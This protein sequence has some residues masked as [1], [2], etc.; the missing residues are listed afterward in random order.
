M[1]YL[2]QTNLFDTLEML[3]IIDQENFIL[4]IRFNELI[5]KYMQNLTLTNNQAQLEQTLSVSSSQSRNE[6][7]HSYFKAFNSYLKLNGSNE[8]QSL[9]AVKE[10]VKDLGDI[11]KQTNNPQFKAHLHF[12]IGKTMILTIKRDNVY[13]KSKIMQ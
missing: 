12:L 8:T 7:F 10:L 13:S 5:F 11:L 6:L 4:C 9:P 3:N 1:L 2:N